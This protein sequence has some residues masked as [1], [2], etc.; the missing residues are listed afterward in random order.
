MHALI[1]KLMFISLIG[2]VLFVSLAH[3]D[4]SEVYRLA[5][6]VEPT[7]QQITLS[8]DPDQAD[9]TGTTSITLSVK[10]GVDRIEFYQ[11]NLEL[12]SV[13]LKSGNGIRIL[14]AES[15]AYE[16][17]R[18]TDGQPINA[19]EYVLEIDFAGK[20]ATN[21]LGMYQTRYEDNNYIYTQFEVMHARQA[22][23]S[24]DEPSY[25]IP[26]QLTISAPAQHI[27]VSNTPVEDTQ[28][29]GDH[30]TVRFARTKPMPSYL[31]A[32]A[33]GPMDA[34][35]IKGLSIPGTVYSP[36]GQGGKAGFAIRHTPPVLKALEDYFD[37]PYLY[38][39]LDF[40]AVPDYA[41][42]AM[43]NVGLVTFRAEM[44]LRGDESR[45]NEAA[46]TISVIAHE[47]AHMW[48]GNLVT[49][50]WWN[51]LWL[52]EAFATWMAEYV[53]VSLYPEYQ[54]NLSLPQDGAFT[55]D[56]RSTAKAIRRDVRDED[57]VLDGLGLNYAKGHSILNMIEGFIG[58]EAMQTGIRD[59]MT[60][61]AWKNTVDDDLWLALGKASGQDIK[62]VAGKYLAQPGY[63][64][65]SVSEQGSVSQ[66]RYQN[67]GQEVPALDWKIPLNV[68]YKM[69]NKVQQASFLLD[70]KQA[71]MPEIA[72][73]EWV[74]P[75]SGGNGYYRW[76]TAPEQVLALLKDIDELSEREKIA[77]QSNSR[78]LL[79]AGEAGIDEHFRVLEAIS[80]DDNPIVFLSVVNEI[81]FIGETIIDQQ[82]LPMFAHYVDK[83]LT[84]WFKRIGLETRADDSEA[85]ILLRPRLLRTLGQ[86]SN[87]AEVIAAATDLSLQFLKQE[88]DIDSNLALEALRV[89]SFHGDDS[90][91]SEY[92]AAYKGS[93]DANFR[94]VLLR[95]M[96]FTNPVSQKRILEFTQS[97]FVNSGDSLRPIFYLFFANKE[98]GFLY[99]W[100][101]E[102]F[103]AVF[104]KAPE[105]SRYFMPQLTG[106][107][108][109]ADNL[110]LTTAFY[111]KR[112]EKFKTSLAKA[113]E[114]SRNCLSLKNRQKE[115]LKTFFAAYSDKGAN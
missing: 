12:K 27:V 101:D 7:F 79:D 57:E 30:K 9:Y 49:M 76:Q 37:Q 66:K 59:Y 40:V 108:C 87:N 110:A 115:A 80:K 61:F 53:M 33:I 52:N 41:F 42:G 111:S 32:Y 23:P 95:S 5:G 105:N 86:F 92:L 17:N 48:Y 15:G 77:L 65:V 104:K 46:E 99:E 2:A 68:K 54:T 24:F 67:F 103:D 31:V 22:F 55:P 28:L 39:K 72:G 25:K 4:N 62:A 97:D 107:Y 82:T 75:D 56:G 16:I 90:I 13:R 21:A 88:G 94:T 71:A 96:Y 10:D 93:D 85:V 83:M 114:D 11:S 51:D 35:P 6:G 74:F 106:S 89:T 18:A 60:R 70:Q 44:L 102:N 113:E 14:T 20:L 91:A 112:D 26:Y 64:I 1:K 43:E 69:D 58:T 63:A 73:A 45:G 81:K 47:L 38:K 8:V 36:K 29:S 84:P 100:L 78:A 34:T 50:A 98:Y 109:D 19:G 3:A